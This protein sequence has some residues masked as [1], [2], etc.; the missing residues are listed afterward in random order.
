M[1]EKLLE[2]FPKFALLAHAWEPRPTPSIDLIFWRKS[3]N[4]NNIEILYLLGLGD[5]SAYSHLKG[6]L[7]EDPKRRLVILEEEGSYIASLQNEELLADLQMHLEWLPKGKERTALLQQLSEQYPSSRIEL[8]ALPGLKSRSLRLQLL[9]R[10][11]LSNALFSDRLY[12][13]QPFENF[14]QTIPHLNGAFYANGLKNAFQGIPVIICGAGPSLQQAIPLLRELEDRVLIIAGGSAIAALTSQGIEPHFGVAID[15]NLEEYRRFRNSFQFE[16]PLLIS[17]RIFPKIFQTCNGPFGY[18]RCGVGGAT[19]LWMEEEMGLTDP[20]LCEGLSDESLSVLSICLAFAVGIGSPTIL[21][22]GVDL[23]YTEGKRYATGVSD[24]TTEL[25]AIEEKKSVADRIVY[26]KDKRGRSVQTAIRWVMEAASIAHF[27]KKHSSIRWINTTEG[28]LPIQNVPFQ[29]LQE[30][31]AQYLT[32]QT[33]LRGKI[34]REIA[35][36]PLPPFNKLDELKTSLQTL[37]SHLEILAGEKKG[38]KALA[39]L[40]LKEELAA[41][42]LFYDIG[43]VLRQLLGPDAAA[44]AKWRAYLTMARKHLANFS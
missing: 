9:R 41:S 25:D 19:E 39:E 28:G 40:E 26:K 11:T 29:P 4:I 20:L 21:L 18:L 16:G 6:W 2:R 36:H 37:I 33:D 8:V 7:H 3:L 34:A 30:A 12:G 17:T 31:A 15:P 44:D 24:E 43:K 10:T 5:G 35:L 38:S 1:H 27:A 13:E 42:I 22:S 32:Q 14:I 23:A